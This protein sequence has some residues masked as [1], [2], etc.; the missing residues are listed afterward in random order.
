MNMFQIQEIKVE[1]HQGRGILFLEK[2]VTKI[3]Q[4]QKMNIVSI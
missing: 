3:Y 4:I 1:V 2:K